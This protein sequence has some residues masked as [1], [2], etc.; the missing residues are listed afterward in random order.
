MRSF[1]PIVLPT[2]LL[3]APAV[4]AAPAPAPTDKV[5]APVR[6]PAGVASP[7]GKVGFLTGAKGTVEAVDLEK[8]E[9]LWQ[10]KEQG[11]PL[12]AFDHFLAVQVKPEGKAN[13]V[14]VL[15][16]DVKDKGKTV[17]ESEAVVFP[18]WVSVVVTYGRSFSSQASVHKGELLLRW[19]ANAFYAGGAR[20]TE[21]IERAARK[22]A[23]G[24]ARIDLKT[25]KVTMA[26]KA[27]V[28]PETALPDELKKLASHQY[29]TGSD[30]KTT[31]FVIGKT[32]SALAV[33]EQGGGVAQMSLKRWDLA[34]G[35]PLE[36]V[37]LLKG[38]S[39]WPQ[40]SADGKHVFVH[41]ALVKEQL[42]PGDY[43]WWVFSLET[44]KQL[45]KLPY[46]EAL[47]EATV[48]GEKVF[49]LA[50]APARPP[51]R[52]GERVQPRSI[53]ALDLISGKLLWE[54]PVEGQRFLPPLP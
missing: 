11:R 35:K 43:A 22:E 39:L 30:W 48:L 46:Q 31:P 20:P 18:E 36:T 37:S 49:Y 7:D 13:S 27:P 44:G 28:E 32:V 14:R 16:L 45:S 4:F 15:V 10:T 21:E 25:G 29:W 6:L 40:V 5:I 12:V 9:L 53:K 47:A 34:T 54:R 26:D 1:F 51:F 17:L 23:S 2:I 41:Q 38:K 50:S 42:P 8:G 24:V 19:K 33:Q 3:L 52:G